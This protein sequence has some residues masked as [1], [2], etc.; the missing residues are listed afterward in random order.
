MIKNNIFNF[1]NS[2]LTYCRGL[3]AKRLP[4][5]VKKV[6]DFPY[7]YGRS[8][9]VIDA[10]KGLLNVHKRIKPVYR[11]WSLWFRKYI[12]TALST[13]KDA[14]VEPKFYWFKRAN[15]IKYVLLMWT[16]YWPI[17]RRWCQMS[18]RHLVSFSITFGS[19]FALIILTFSTFL[20]CA[21]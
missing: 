16:G 14:L 4:G 3:T 11:F 8:D 15:S 7:S 2:E 9:L 21:G 5:G 20:L 13:V 10:D 6:D 19:V 18:I 1:C 17:F 12:Q